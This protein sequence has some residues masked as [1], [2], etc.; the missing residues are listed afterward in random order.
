[1]E[2][3]L[4][5]LLFM[6]RSKFGDVVPKSFLKKPHAEIN[7]P[8]AFLTYLKSHPEEKLSPRDVTDPEKCAKLV[9]RIQKELGVEWSFGGWLENRSVILQDSYLKTT[10]SWIHLGIDI[11]LPVGTP[12]RAA[13]N[14]TVHMVDS[15]YPEEGGWGTFVIL[16]HKLNGTIFYSI[17]GHLNKKRLV[18]KGQRISRGD[19]IGRVGNT[20]ENGFWFPHVHFQFISEQ[21]MRR[22]EHP[23]TLDGY[24]KQKNLSYLRKH[25]PDPLVVLPMADLPKKK[26]T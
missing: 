20:E 17:S 13:L 21:E 23:F 12:I 24:G 5:E 8:D 19:V 18:V 11:N 3:T 22:R 1:M 16:E 7:F 4:L 26:A 25:Y 2:P 10:K 9:K 14:G 15:D 6:N